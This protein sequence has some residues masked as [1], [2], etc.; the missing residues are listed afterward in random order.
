M[1][2]LTLASPASYGLKGA[3]TEYYLGQP[4]VVVTFEIRKNAE[5]GWGLVC[6]WESGV[7]TSD[8]YVGL[9]CEQL[10]KEKVQSADSYQI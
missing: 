3:S 7:K 8:G 9:S 1:Q 10:L 4:L 5:Q 6:T 2:Y